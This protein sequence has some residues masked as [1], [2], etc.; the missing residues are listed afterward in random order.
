VPIPPELVALLR[1][2]IERFGNSEDGRLFRSER[3]NPIQ[4]STWVATG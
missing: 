4:L 2:H 1:D 3:G